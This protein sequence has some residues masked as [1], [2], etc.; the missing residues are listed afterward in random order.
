LLGPGKTAERLTYDYLRDRIIRGDL[1]GGSAIR[2]QDVATRL[3]VSRIPVRDALRHLA[4]EGLI[5]VESNRR[6]VVTSLTVTDIT[7]LFQMRAVLEGLAARFA[8]PQM[9]PP[10]LDRLSLLA[11]QMNRACSNVDEWNPIHQEFHDLICQQAGMPRL[12]EEIVRMRS[13]VEPYLRVIIS[14]YGIAARSG[15]N[16]R[17]VLAAL[18]RRDGVGAERAMRDLITRALNQFANCIATSEQLNDQFAGGN[19]HNK[20]RR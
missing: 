3:G 19:R 11:D 9:T 14:T 5:T 12:H 2:Q 8:A 10:I 6:V 15:S 17:P 7:E 4:A 20:R 13:A 1:P 18:R 16:H